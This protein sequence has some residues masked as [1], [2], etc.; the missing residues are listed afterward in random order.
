MNKKNKLYCVNYHL[1]NNLL[2]KSKVLEIK[3]DRLTERISAVKNL[4]NSLLLETD[5]LIYSMEYTAKH[6]YKWYTTYRK[7]TK[8]YKSK[9]LQSLNQEGK[10]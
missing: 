2:S 8:Q 10:L 1:Y 5:I 4:I 3:S 6:L 7:Y 9:I